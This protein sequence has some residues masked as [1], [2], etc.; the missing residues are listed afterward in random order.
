MIVRDEVVVIERC[1]DSV[2]EHM[3]RQI[4]QDDDPNDGLARAIVALSDRDYFKA[5]AKWMRDPVSG[6]HEWSRSGWRCHGARSGV[7]CLRQE[8]SIGRWK[9]RA[10]GYCWPE[11][12]A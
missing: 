9:T 2:R 8:R 7:D 3:E 5:F 10:R 11:S 6:G 1:I 12:L 4:R